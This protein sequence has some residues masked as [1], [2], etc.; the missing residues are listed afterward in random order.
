MGKIRGLFEKIRDS[1]RPESLKQSEFLA[2]ITDTKWEIKLEGLFSLRELSLK[3]DSAK[4][5]V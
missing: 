1:S 4:Q 5:L 2:K 3:D